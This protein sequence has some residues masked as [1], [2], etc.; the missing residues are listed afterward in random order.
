MVHDQIQL[1][2]KDISKLKED[3]SGIK[4]DM[5][6]EEKIDGEEYEKLKTTLKELRTDKKIMEDD[7]ME[8][9][10]SD[11]HYNKL[12]E[13]KMKKE[14]EAA[15]LN[16]KLQKALATLPPKPFEM[17]METDSGPVRVQVQPEMKMY[18]NGKEFKK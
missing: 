10:H 3:L 1:L 9:L 16:E 6:H 11:D 13:L 5:K 2:L 18:L 8:E 14:E 12:R 7:H 4:K 17:L 15:Q